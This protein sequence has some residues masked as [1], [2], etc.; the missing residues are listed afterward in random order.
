LHS[1]ESD[2]IVPHDAELAASRWIRYRMFLES[3]ERWETLLRS[4]T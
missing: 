4:L 3:L 2:S 1:L